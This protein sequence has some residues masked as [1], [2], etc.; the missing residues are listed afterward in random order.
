MIHPLSVVHSAARVHPSVE[1]GP[2]CVIDENV[3]VGEGCRL[4]AGVRLCG[5]T[6]IG[7]GNVFHTGCVIGDAPQDLKY[8]GEPT[9]LVI[10]DQNVF[11]EHATVHRSNKVSE[12]TTVG[13]NNLFM[14][15]AHVGHNSSVGNHVVVANG[16]L[17][18]GHV[19]VGDRA[20]ISGCCLLHQYVRV[21]TLAIMQGGAGISRDLPPYTVATGNNRICG[22]NIVGLRRNGA[23]PEERLELKRLYR[24]LFLSGRA[25]RLAISELGEGFCT[26]ASRTMIDFVA[27]SRR[28]VCIHGRRGAQTEADSV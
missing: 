10:G 21:G 27:S 3:T 19:T 13:S 26:P 2:F 22:L 14:A 9:R 25:P 15:G 11:R 28:G 23:S 24:R 7:S 6:T 20:F 5:H 8:K 12:A 4:E 16:A 17:L 1:V 18:G